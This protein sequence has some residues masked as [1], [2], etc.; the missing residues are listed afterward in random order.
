MDDRLGEM[1]VIHIRDKGL[2]YKMVIE[3]HKG[4]TRSAIGKRGKNMDSHKGKYT[5]VL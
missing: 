1:V 5:H 3:I 2:V 4:K